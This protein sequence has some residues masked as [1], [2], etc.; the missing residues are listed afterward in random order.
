MFMASRQVILDLEADLKV[1]LKKWSEIVDGG[2]KTGDALGGDACCYVST[3][4][5]LPVVVSDEYFFNIRA[6]CFYEIGNVW[7][8]GTSNFV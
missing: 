6:K 1:G 2:R 7:N 4:F 3:G 8:W 5:S